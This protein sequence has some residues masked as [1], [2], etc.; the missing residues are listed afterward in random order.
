MKWTNFSKN[1]KLPR[2]T[3]DE[4]D[5]L[6]SLITIKSNWFHNQKPSKNQIISLAK[7]TKYLT[8]K[9]FQHNLS[10]NKSKYFLTNFMKPVLP[11]YQN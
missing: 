8:K 4:M 5:N 11:W 10:E 2:L 9:S 6:S 7:S 1:Q 3:Q